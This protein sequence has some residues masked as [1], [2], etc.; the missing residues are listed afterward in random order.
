M[1]CFV[2]ASCAICNRAIFLAFFLLLSVFGQTSRAQEDKTVDQ[3]DPTAMQQPSD[4]VSRTA[5]P[6]EGESEQAA[7]GESDS[8]DP[9]ANP[10]DMEK[11]KRRYRRYNTWEGSTGGMHL[12]DPLSGAAGSVRIQVGVQGFGASDFLVEDDAV[13]SIAQ[14]LSIS[15]T[16]TEYFELYGSLSNRSVSVDQSD[17]ETRREDP[18]FENVFHSH[19]DAS[20][21]LKA[22]ALVTPLLSLG[23]DVSM[24]LPNQPE[25]VGIQLDAVGICVRGDL[26]L[27]LRYLEEPVPFVGRFNMD[28]RFDHSE[29]L[30]T[31]TEDKR[32]E[33]YYSDD[34]NRPSKQRDPDHLISRV[35][36]FGMGINRVDLFTLGLGFEIPLQVA[37]E[38]YLQPI[39]EWRMSFPVNR[40]EF[41]CPYREVPEESEATSEESRYPDESCGDR[42]DAGAFPSTLGF[43]IR[44]VT[45]IRGV[46]AMLGIDVGLT[47]TSTF[48]RELKPTAPYEIL[49]AASY[50][51]DARPPDVRIVERKV[52]VEPPKGRVK[53]LVTQSDAAATPIAGATIVFTG[54]EL[55]PISTGDDGRFNSYS[56]VPGKI[57]MSVSH[58]DFQ[59]S[60]CYADIQPKGGD[61]DVTCPLVQ[62][63]RTGE[64]KG[65]VTDIWNNGVASAT[66]EL[67]GAGRHTITTDHD[68]RFNWPVQPGEYSLRI[69]APG[70]FIRMATVTVAPREKVSRDFMLAK[71]RARSSVT[72]KGDAIRIKGRLSFDKSTGKISEKSAVIVTEIADLILRNPQ[73]RKV[74][75]FGSV[76]GATGDTMVAL[77]RAL[78]IKHSLVNAGVAP[79]RIEAVGGDQRR[80][81]IT[82]EQD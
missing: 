12:V 30:I 11:W 46:S 70:Y 81:L 23:G 67:S 55:S 35:E 51:Y 53:G 6:A 22:G 34:S 77:A 65:S 29:S 19:G 5:L 2:H 45:P 49:F 64:I 40:R 3:T 9:L 39:M 48:V 82:V 79:E 33:N 44:G 52:P 74:K 62:L 4:E 61:V 24:L 16:P 15:W 72:L 60:T 17:Y 71:R 69:D 36:R 76:S 73:I 43:G 68:G 54:T 80:V 25:A 47:G 38:F 32:F 59:S 7:P 14:R 37:E 26:T 66:I 78:N 1:Q 31:D 27:D 63:P 21:G 56:F 8:S 41:V 75:I 28:Y 50:D 58:P 42:E 13:E 10:V 57:E 20:L 18:R